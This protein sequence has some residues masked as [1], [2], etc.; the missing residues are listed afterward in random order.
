[1]KVKENKGWIKKTLKRAIIGRESGD[2]TLKELFLTEQ[3]RLFLSIKCGLWTC[4]YGRYLYVNDS[5]QK[6]GARN[7]LGI[8]VIASPYD[9][10]WSKQYG[11]KYSVKVH[12]I[13]MED[14]Q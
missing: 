13:P 6:W 3:G 4:K 14:L 12:K 2:I 5:N 1:M 9:K 10:V 11:T 8:G 7:E